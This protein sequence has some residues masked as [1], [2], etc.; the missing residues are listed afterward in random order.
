MISTVIEILMKYEQHHQPSGIDWKKGMRRALKWIFIFLIGLIGIGFIP[1]GIKASEYFN[2]WLIVVLGTLYIICGLVTGD[3]KTKAIIKP[4]SGYFLLLQ[5]KITAESALMNELMSV[6]VHQLEQAVKRF[7]HEKEMMTSRMGFLFGAMN[8]LA[9]I[10]A[11]AAVAMTIHKV[12]GLSN[13]TLSDAIV[14]FLSAF[15]FGVYLGCLQLG[16][17]T[18]K[19]E[20]TIFTLRTAIESIQQHKIVASGESA[21][22]LAVNRDKEGPH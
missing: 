16:H 19:L 4:V 11:L 3:A 15:A 22:A 2:I 17:V 7:Q 20:S 8:K 6:E 10:P 12:S 5:K 9:I 18:Y 13:L 21:A 14:Y 1:P